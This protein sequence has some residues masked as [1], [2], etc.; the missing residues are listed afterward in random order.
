M[1]RA[2]KFLFFV[3]AAAVVACETTTESVTAPRSDKLLPESHMMNFPTEIL[4]EI[5]AK[6]PISSSVNLARSSRKLLHIFAHSALVGNSFSFSD[7]CFLALVNLLAADCENASKFE[8]S[9]TTTKMPI[10]QYQAAITL[11]YRWHIV[12]VAAEHK[13]ALLRKIV[14]HFPLVSCL[15][16]PVLDRGLLLAAAEATSGSWPM[17][18][19]RSSSSRSRSSVDRLL[20]L[21]KE[22]QELSAAAA[23]A[24]CVA[25]PVPQ[26]IQQH[27]DAVRVEMSRVAAA[28]TTAANDGM[29]LPSRASPQHFSA[30]DN[31]A[32]NPQFALKL[33]DKCTSLRNTPHVDTFIKLALNG[34]QIP[35]AD[36]MRH[37]QQ[38]PQHAL[39][40]F[41]PFL[42]LSDCCNIF[43]HDIDPNRLKPLLNSPLFLS[44]V[45]WAPHSMLRSFLVEN[46][47]NEPVALNPLFLSVLDLPEF[48]PL[49]ELLL[50]VARKH[51][52]IQFFM[53]L[54][55]GHINPDRKINGQTILPKSGL[56]QFAP[57]A[58]IAI[59]EV[60]TARLEKIPHKE[61]NGQIY[62]SY[63][64]LRTWARDQHVPNSN[65]ER[66]L[67]NRRI[68]AIIVSIFIIAGL[69]LADFGLVIQSLVRSHQS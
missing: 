23:A 36:F 3:L 53:L 41:V 49:A 17:R 10:K 11:Y 13:V 64:D 7:S 66:C 32:G 42:N 69:F 65:V 26:E 2:S 28:A 38:L 56:F 57:P 22:D 31:F 9:I 48:Q 47:D 54:R 43:Q 35:Y 58:T 20:Q 63:S 68:F 44:R 45:R 62:L 12:R 24:L 30:G 60:F 5:Y 25:P 52:P 27:V 55:N 15:M 59:S 34:I 40:D 14:K 61:D 18:S 33:F 1:T 21:M 39:A 46:M 8:C 16:W 6:L 67:R 50:P 4:Q 19:F 37:V 29:L 51:F